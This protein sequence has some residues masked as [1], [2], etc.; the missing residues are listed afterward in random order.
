MRPTQTA[1]R[2]RSAF[3]LV[4]LLVVIAIIGLIA[5]LIVGATMR[6]IG[7]QAQK[8][9]QTLVQKI[10]YSLNQQISALYSKASV[11][12]PYDLTGQCPA[13]ATNIMNMAGGDARRARVIWGKLRLKQQFPMSFAEALNPDGGAGLIAPEPAYK[14]VAP[15]VGTM[16]PQQ[17][18]AVCLYLALKNNRSGASFDP[19]TLSPQELAN[20]NTPGVKYLTDAWKAPLQFYRWPATND[21]NGYPN[22]PQACPPSFLDNQDPEGLLSDNAWNSAGFQGVC[23]PVFAGQS[24]DVSAYVY[25]TGGPSG[26]AVCSFQLR[27][28]G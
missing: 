20:T 25:S 24:Y 6:V 8:N 14:V 11:E 5:A 10:G 22:S 23:H 4:E 7:V 21:P 27:F 12:P 1:R 28:G 26:M 13:S 18:Q 15:L 9:T 17:E 19:D 3:T 2:D 16:T